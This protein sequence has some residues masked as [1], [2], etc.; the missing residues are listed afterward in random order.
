MGV[1]GTYDLL[2]RLYDVPDGKYTIVRTFTEELG[3]TVAFVGKIKESAAELI[4]NVER[5]VKNGTYVSPLA[6]ALSH[7]NLRG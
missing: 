1:I 2:T 3:L 5:V 7:A 4:P 6:K